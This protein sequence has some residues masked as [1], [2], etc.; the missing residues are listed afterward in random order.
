[1]AT[2]VSAT[3]TAT[4]GLQVARRS[5]RIRTPHIAVGP[6]QVEQ[7]AVSRVR[8]GS[9]ARPRTATSRWTPC[10]ISSLRWSRGWAA[11]MPSPS[12]STQTRARSG[13]CG[14]AWRTTAGGDQRHDV[15]GQV[16]GGCA[17]DRGA[18]VRRDAVARRRSPERD[19]RRLPVPTGR[20]DPIDPPRAPGDALDAQ[21]CPKGCRRRRRVLA[22]A[23]LATSSSRPIGGPAVRR[24]TRPAYV[25]P[26]SRPRA[27]GATIR[28][29]ASRWT[30]LPGRRLVRVE[31][32]RDRSA[33][34]TS[35][36]RRAAG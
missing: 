24:A 28:F 2:V 29:R 15:E 26:S 6:C 30:T 34:W 21:P 22:P 13:S 11:S 5:L 8:V 25:A 14:T 3:S 23:P 12:R 18:P 33:A 19:A 17:A 36:S 10:D 27:P 35:T 32:G 31:R 1:M 16:R 20:R 4:A 7:V 9:H